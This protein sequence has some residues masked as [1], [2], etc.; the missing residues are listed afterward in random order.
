MRRTIST[1]TA[2]A[3]LTVLM[4]CASQVKGTPLSATYSS[5]LSGWN[6]APINE[7]MV[8]DGVYALIVPGSE[9]ARQGLIGDGHDVLRVD[10]MGTVG[11]QIDGYNNAT[12]KLG[13]SATKGYMNH[14]ADNV[15]TLFTDT[16]AAHISVYESTTWLCNSLFPPSPLPTPYFPYNTTYCPLPAGDFAMNLSIPLYRSYA[17]TTL[18]TQV[19]IVDT[20][21]DALILAC[22]NIDFTPYKHDGWYYNLFLYLPTAVAI[23]F[24][25]VSWSA[26]FATGWIVGSG[27]AEY[28]T[29]EGQHYAQHAF[30]AGVGGS[31]THL[32]G[33]SKRDV[34][35]RKWGT[36]IISGLSGERLSVSSALLRFG[37]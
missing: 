6:A 3:A 16:S 32:P 23:G 29:K 7:Q 19:R 11:T 10:L 14:N 15:A 24:W 27:V 35:M 2:L 4:E 12:N 34:R 22:Y 17:L 28:G 20:S 21:A 30:G 25:V 31:S 8:F 1:T 37:E 18:R 13:M 5:C 9:A 36:M 26:R 33:V